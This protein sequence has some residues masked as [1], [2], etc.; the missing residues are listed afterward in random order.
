MK[1]KKSDKNAVPIFEQVDSIFDNIRRTKTNM[2]LCDGASRLL[3]SLEREIEIRPIYEKFKNGVGKYQIEFHENEC[4]C[5]Q[6]LTEEF[7]NMRLLGSPYC[8]HLKGILSKVE[9]LMKGNWRDLEFSPVNGLRPLWFLLLELYKEAC[10]VIASFGGA[11]ILKGKCTTKPFK[12][13]FS[14]NLAMSNSCNREQIF[15]GLLIRLGGCSIDLNSLEGQ[16]IIAAYGKGFSSAKIVGITINF[17]SDGILTYDFPRF[18]NALFEHDKNK[19]T[20]DSTDPIKALNSLFLLKDTLTCNDLVPVSF[21]SREKPY[22]LPEVAQA[23]SNQEKLLRMQ[24]IRSEKTEKGFRENVF[25]AI[26][27]FIGRVKEESYTRSNL[28]GPQLKSVQ[29]AE[30]YDFLY[31][32]IY[33]RIRSFLNKGKHPKQEEI[34]TWIKGSVSIPEHLQ[35]SITPNLLSDI[36]TDIAN[37]T[38]WKNRGGRPIS[39]KKKLPKQT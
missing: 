38:G 9:S 23:Y 37:L 12:Q 21:P 28:K 2:E 3:N 11:K 33:W 34:K 32:K 31:N 27:L 15:Q 22:I 17:E 1:Q 4:K 13:D 36:C 6:W 39:S 25:T 7:A 26:E 19:F 10:E 24:Q 18:V 29:S 20:I 16:E 5:F 14:F 30:A 8:E 35:S